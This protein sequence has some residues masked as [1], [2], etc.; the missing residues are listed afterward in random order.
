M[1]HDNVTRYV[2]WQLCGKTELQ[3]VD[4][5]YKQAPERVVGN[6]GLKVLWDF[7]VCCDGLLKLE[8]RTSSSLK[9]QFRRE[10]I[11]KLWN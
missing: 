1:W 9:Y 8:G 5:W 11:G 3:R 2:N 4:Q 10:E 6:A 7:K